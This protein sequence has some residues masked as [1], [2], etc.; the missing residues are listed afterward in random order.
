MVI[1]HENHQ[2]LE[3]AFP[4]SDYTQYAFTQTKADAI[5]DLFTK[6]HGKP[7]V[8]IVLVPVDHYTPVDTA[9]DPSG[10]VE[11]LKGVTHPSVGTDGTITDPQGCLLRWKSAGWNGDIEEV[12]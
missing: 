9:L 4:S 12:T 8:D 1:N 3:T 7:V 2:N 11:N 5:R 6:N 10:L